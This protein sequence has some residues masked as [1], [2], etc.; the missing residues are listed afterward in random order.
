MIACP[1]EI[2]AYEYDNAYTPR[3]MKCTMCAPRVTKGLLPGCVENC[4]TEALSFGR[5]E[6]LI[7]MA[8]DRIKAHPDRYVDHIY[9]E[10]EMGGTSWLYLSGV[11][12]KNIGMR[13]DLGM[14][15]APSL[16]SG[17]LS[18][19][20]I[21]AGLWPVL[22]LGIYAASKRKEKIAQVEEQ[23]AVD[24]A[25]EKTASEAK[26]T[27]EKALEKAKQEKDAEIKKEV[28]KALEAQNSESKGDV[29]DV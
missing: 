21:I 16:T 2:P 3:I 7:K 8:R 5:R 15:P 14:M 13:E 27:L 9:G 22:L 6:D 12:F 1:F 10:H 28:K 29:S 24:A 20:P 11:T 4:P 17:A 19:V 26:A 25:I 18:T 23:T